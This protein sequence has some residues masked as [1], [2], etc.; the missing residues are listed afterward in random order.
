MKKKKIKKR[1]KKKLKKLKNQNVHMYIF[2]TQTR[3]VTYYM[4]DMSSHQGRF[5]T[6]KKTTTVLITAK[7]WS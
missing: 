3:T 1:K 5:H 4:T 2:V 7:I 6:T